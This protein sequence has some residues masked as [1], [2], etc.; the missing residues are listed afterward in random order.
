MPLRNSWKSRGTGRLSFSLVGEGRCG[1]SIEKQTSIAT[2]TAFLSFPRVHEY[3]KRQEVWSRKK[4]GQWVGLDRTGL[5][6]TE[7]L[8]GRL[9]WSNRWQWRWHSSSLKRQESRESVEGRGQLRTDGPRRSCYRNPSTKEKKKN[10]KRKGKEE[11]NSKERSVSVRAC[12]NTWH[13]LVFFSTPTLAVFSVQCCSSS[14]AIDNRVVKNAEFVS[15]F[16]SSRL[17]AT[18]G[19]CHLLSRLP[20]SHI[21]SSTISQS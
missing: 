5:D 14:I 21:R 6:W 16:Q 2:G 8:K 20:S 17:L 13:P 4:G 9:W 1:G 10:R 7:R 18:W 19:E 11:I 3:R 15:W 12:G